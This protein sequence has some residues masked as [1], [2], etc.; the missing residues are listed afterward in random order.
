MKNTKGGKEGRSSDIWEKGLQRGVMTSPQTPV[1]SKPHF[2]LL[3]LFQL[4]AEDRCRLEEGQVTRTWLGFL[5]FSR[6]KRVVGTTGVPKST[7]TKNSVLWIAGIYQQVNLF[8]KHFQG[9]RRE[10]KAQ[11]RYFPCT[12]KILK[13]LLG[14][15]AC[16]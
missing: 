6:V 11:T 16:L 13:K 2:I 15:M 5:V 12:F 7:F 14:S 4:E 8:E 9:D 3:W 10:V 1:L